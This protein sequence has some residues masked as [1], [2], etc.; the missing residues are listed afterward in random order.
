MGLPTLHRVRS[1]VALLV[2]VLVAGLTLTGSIPAAH[3][4][5]GTL[6][7][8]VTEAG[9]GVPLAGVSVQAFCW[10]VAGNDSGELCAETQTVANGTYS[11]SMAPGIYKVS[12]DRFPTHARQ[13][14]GGGKNLGDVTSVEVLVPDG[15]AATGIGA[16]LMPLR[17]A[18]GTVTGNGGPVGGINVTA[19]QLSGGPS[20]GWAPVDGVVTALDGSYALHLTDGTYRVGFSDASG[21]YRTEFFDDAVTVEQADDVVVAGNDVGGINADL[22]LNHAITGAVTVDGIDMPGVT[23]SAYQA[24]ASDPTGWVEVKV[25]STGQGGSYAL[26][27][28][29]GTYRIK[30]QTFQAR[31]DAVFYPGVSSVDAAADV[32]L[33][34]ADV[35]DISV[36]ISTGEIDSGPA[37]TGTVTLAGTGAPVGGVAVTAYRWDAQAGFWIQVRQ[38]TTAEDGTYALFVPEGTYRVGFSDFQGR[39][40]PVFYG[41]ADT[42][43]EAEDVVQTGEGVPGID[44]QLVENHSISGAIT[45]DPLPDLPPARLRPG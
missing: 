8:T 3:A 39:Y 1:L 22:G 13:F 42:L 19:Y 18:A 10:Q 30:F 20:P 7:G 35:P 38:R 6:S 41:G 9:T 29:D 40:K 28:A 15:G 32:V 21:P 45:S 24:D 26:Y 33:A 25:T 37:I 11:M 16:A 27:L 36:A 5:N 43:E 23:V 44:A 12:F 14:Y 31:F 2:G 4:A 34:G 17:L